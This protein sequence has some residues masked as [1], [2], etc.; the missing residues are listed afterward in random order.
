MNSEMCRELSLLIESSVN[1]ML[2]DRQRHRFN[3]ILAS[4]KQAR[5]FY[6]EY[7]QVCSSLNSIG[8]YVCE[9]DSFSQE[10]CLN[11]LAELAWYEKYAPAVSRSEKKPKEPA[12]KKINQDL[13]QKQPR[14]ISWLTAVSGA[15]SAAAIIFFLIYA[16]LFVPEMKKVAALEDSYQAEWGRQVYNKKDPIYT[17][18]ENI[19]L[20]KGLAEFKTDRGVKL[21]VEGPAEFRFSS[22]SEINLDYGSI[23]SNVPVEGV[24]FAVSTDN[25]RVVDLGTEFGVTAD[26]KGSSQLHVFSGKT[27]LISSKGWLNNTAFDVVESMACKVTEA[28]LAVEKIELAKNKF[29]RHF[30]ETAKVVWRG[31]KRIDLADI[32]G[33]GNGLGTGKTAFAINSLNG[34]FGHRRSIRMIM[35]RANSNRFNPV[36]DLQFI[37]GVFVPASG[38]GEVKISSEG[39]SFSWMP[40]ASGRYWGGI[41]NGMVHF[42]NPDVFR[43]NLSLAGEVLRYPKAKGIFMHPNQGITF[44]LRRIREAY[45]NISLAG[46]TAEFG[47]SDT[48]FDNSKLKLNK[49]FSDTNMPSCDIYVL[50][51]GEMEFHKEAQTPQDQPCDIDVSIQ[52]SDEFLTVITAVPADR[53]KVNY[54][55]SL[56]KDPVLN[57]AESR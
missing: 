18:S 33:G 56:L 3:E 27:R 19:Q 30:D 42:E 34:D 47:L 28:S 2:T 9:Q 55:W 50:L 41:I 54:C 22:I 20:K 49:N 29:A 6:R 44:D 36:K 26:K 21:V 11:V 37:D 17:G 38:N 39:H 14:H 7:I 5:D 43:H 52:S 40:R 8:G 12:K 35:K 57:L 4:D 24:G 16:N 45:G 48:V 23:Y 31:E 46:F 25:S 51:D 15:V 32:V 53:R 1:G 10:N 13:A